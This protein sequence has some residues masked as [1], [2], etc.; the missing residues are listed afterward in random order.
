MTSSQLS[1]LNICLI[2]NPVTFSAIPDDEI[3]KFVLFFYKIK[4]NYDK[5]NNN[6]CVCPVNIN[7]IKTG[8]N[9]AI[10]GNNM[11]GIQAAL[12]YK[13]VLQ[14]Y[15]NKNNS[16]LFSS[17]LFKALE[18]DGQR[19]RQATNYFRDVKCCQL[20]TISNYN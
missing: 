14:Q 11:N 6:L 17:Y 16:G 19:K 3:N 18:I 20:Q 13:Y 15:N 1:A 2:P 9:Y 4:N 5:Y 7:W 12:F 8:V 10:S